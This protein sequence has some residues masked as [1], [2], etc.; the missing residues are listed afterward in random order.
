MRKGF[1]TITL[2]VVLT[3][4]ALSL[5][6]CSFTA[7]KPSVATVEKVAQ[8]CINPEV[9]SNSKEITK[10][11][12]NAGKFYVYSMVDSRGIEFEVKLHHR[13]ITIVEPIPPFFSNDRKFYNNYTSKVVEHYKDDISAILNRDNVVKFTT[14]GNITVTFKQETPYEEIARIIMDIDTLLAVDYA[15]GGVTQIMP[16]SD[17]N[18]YWSGYGAATIRVDIRN[19]TDTDFDLFKVITLSGNNGSKLTYEQVLAELNEK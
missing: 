8:E 19:A 14:N 5:T 17:P 18:T 12:D 1:R 9:K 11:K 2:G 6:G 7:Y 4:M 10:G 13:Y 3:T 16:Q 15:C